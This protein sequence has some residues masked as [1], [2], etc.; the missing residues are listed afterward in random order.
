MF[1][2]DIRPAVGVHEPLQAF[3]L[4]RRMADN[5]QQL[6]VIPHIAFQW[7]NVEIT[8]DQRGPVNRIRPA[9]HP[10]QKI[11]LLSKFGVYLPVR[12]VAA[13]RDI[14]VFDNHA[15]VIGQFH[16]HMARL[17]IILPVMPRKFTQRHPADCGDAVIALLPVHGEMVISQRAKRIIGKLMFL[18]F[19]FLQTQH[20][21]CLLG[22]KTFDN[23]HPQTDRIDI[24]C[25][26]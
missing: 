2:P 21:G 3:H 8:H 19:D 24:P 1:A 5:L 22:Q 20:I 18:T 6:L 11:E 16:A 4:N 25:S 13:R 26:D 23:R 15:L 9:G 12:L 17:A 10:L 7:G 14:D